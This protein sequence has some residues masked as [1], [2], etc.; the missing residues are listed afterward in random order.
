[1]FY[2]VTV[3]HPHEIKFG[4]PSDRAHDKFMLIEADNIRTARNIAAERIIEV[5]KATELELVTAGREGWP[6][7]KSS[8]TTTDDGQ[9]ALDLPAPH[10]KTADTGGEHPIHPETQP[11]HPDDTPQWQPK[12][13]SAPHWLPNPV[14]QE[15]GD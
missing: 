2:K 14:S 12:T 13:G 4:F 11:V 9:Q 5:E 10:A 15:T 3:K 1:M 6:I 8:E 7:I